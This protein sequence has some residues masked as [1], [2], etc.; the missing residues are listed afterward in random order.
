M[1]TVQQSKN[2]ICIVLSGGLSVRM[3][4]PKALLRFDENSTF[5]QHL[6]NVYNNACIAKIIV[7]KNINIEINDMIFYEKNVEFVNNY[8]PEKG[9]LYSIQL[10]LKQYTDAEYCY[11]QNIDN[12]FITTELLNDLWLAKDNAEYITPQYNEKGGHPV[13]ISKTIIDNLLTVT[14]YDNTL[15]NLLK[16]YTRHRFKTNDENCLLNINTPGD[17][18]KYILNNNKIKDYL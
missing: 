18:E 3:N 1:D 10:G 13:L 7:V 11:I 9:R 17:Y 14:N 2:A 8:F 6:I 5:L 15:Q 16:P 4:S 12:P